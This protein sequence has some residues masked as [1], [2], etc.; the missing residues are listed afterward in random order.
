MVLIFIA[1]LEGTLIQLSMKEKKKSKKNI[2]FSQ[3]RG[4]GPLKI[5]IETIDEILSVMML[6]SQ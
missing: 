5:I 2:F 6:L 3:E 1:H 4:G